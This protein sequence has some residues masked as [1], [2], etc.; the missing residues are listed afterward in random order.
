MF[1]VQHSI[2]CLLLV[3][4]VA[5]AETNLPVRALGG[6]V[7]QVGEVTLDQSNRTVR[8]PA[9]VNMR[10]ETVEYAIVHRTGK[11]HES[12]FR[13]E[14]RP[15]DIHV[16]MLLLDVKPMMTNSFGGDNQAAPR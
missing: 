15:R 7:F 11:T 16:A 3:A 14:V 10:D 1:K 6:G 12:I 5:M 13:T 8:F 9:R 4:S 2:A